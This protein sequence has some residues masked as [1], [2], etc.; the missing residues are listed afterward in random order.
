MLKSVK[1]QIY[2]TTRI[3]NS[4]SNSKPSQAKQSINNDRSKLPLAFPLIAAKNSF[5]IPLLFP[6][7]KS[8]ETNLNIMHL[9]SRPI[10]SYSIPSKPYPH[11]QIK[12]AHAGN[13]QLIKKT[14]CRRLRTRIAKLQRKAKKRKQKQNGRYTP[15]MYPTIRSSKMI[16]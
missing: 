8:L 2:N 4:N 5:F 16:K 15:N 11:I 6:L 13:T 1:Y 14:K 9:S 10:P 3:P 7:L 12:P